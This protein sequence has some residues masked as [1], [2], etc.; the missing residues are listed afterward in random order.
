[1]PPL[2]LQNVCARF[3]ETYIKASGKFLPRELVPLTM[4]L[5]SSTSILF[6]STTCHAISQSPV[7]SRPRHT[8]EWEVLWVHGACLYQE[9]VSPTIQRIETLAVR[10]VKA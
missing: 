10:D 9:L 1:M 8:Y 7:R 4:R 2:E 6:P 3:V 5:L